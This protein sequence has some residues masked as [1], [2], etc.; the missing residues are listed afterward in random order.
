[1]K[2][3]FVF[4]VIEIVVL[5]FLVGSKSVVE[6]VT[7]EAGSDYPAASLFFKNAKREASFVTDLSTIPMNNPGVYDVEI[8]LG[9]RSFK[10]MLQIIDTTAPTGEVQ[11]I[12]LTQAEEIKPEDFFSSITDATDV[13]VTYKNA[14]DMS[15]PNIQPVTLVLTD[16]SGN[17]SEYE[18]T[19]RI[20]KAVNM[21]QVEVGSTELVMADFL[22][23]E[24]TADNITLVGDTLNL[25]QIGSYPVQLNIDGIVCDSTVEVVD[26]IPPAATVVQ[27]DGFLGTPVAAVTFTQDVQDKTEV[28]VAYQAEPDFNHQGEQPVTIVLTDAGGNKTLLETSL[29]LQP[30][31]EPPHI[32]GAKKAMAY[33]GVPVSYKKGVYAED[34]KDGEVAITVDSSQVNLK[35]AGEYPVFYSAVDSSGNK[36]EV[37]ITIT[38]MEQTVTREELDQLA[39]EV[40]AKII[41]DEMTALE[42]TF[43]V[44]QY[45]N[46][47]VLYTGTSDKSD[48]MKEAQNGIVRG[49]GDC[50]TYYSLSHL[51]LDKIGVQT[52]SVERASIGDETRHYW[53]MVN[54]GEGWYHFDACPHRVYF[55]SFMLTTE[56]TDAFSKLVGKNDYYYRYD[57]EKY[58]ETEA[59]PTEE[60]IALR[61]SD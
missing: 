2:F 31:L 50:F 7:I 4:L 43:A 52:L 16:S 15:K 12:D 19:L 56:E 26:T 42:K 51:L 55:V 59:Q 27:Q 40:L 48:W 5:I 34:N 10:S 58:P 39:D 13:T 8:R 22:K 54:Y 21:L 18:T 28:S 49:V 44:Y 1:M 45:V 35:V 25:S 57:K 60:I 38:M 11:P 17:I 23:P 41:T 20:S 37:E 33:I 46:R 29:N 30:D 32:Y 24:V 47:H 6:T 14:P 36:T 53:H 3:L 9:K 61:E